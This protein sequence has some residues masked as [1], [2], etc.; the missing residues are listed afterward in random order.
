M[1]ELDV[2]RF[3][4][5]CRNSF[6]GRMIRRSNP[7]L[8]LGIRFTSCSVILIR[9]VGCSR[10][11]WLRADPRKN[12]SVNSRASIL[13][14][15]FE[16]QGKAAF[17]EPNATVYNVVIWLENH[18]FGDRRLWGGEA[19]EVA[20]GR[21]GPVPSTIVL[22]M[23]RLFMTNDTRIPWR[24]ILGWL[25]VA[26]GVLIIV[27]DFVES[28]HTFRAFRNA[29]KDGAI[30]FVLG[31]IPLVEAGFT[32]RTERIRQLEREN[33]ALR[34]GKSEQGSNPGKPLA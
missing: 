24:K 32:E 28:E 8:R 33:A 1:I 9:R 16:Q 7:V 20:G 5:S 17:D 10:Q 4:A 15:P 21:L 34:A 18:S 6:R 2:S 22:A 31:A 29:V 27:L 11:T 14:Q 19:R 23:R 26:A 25:L 3:R 13:P 30:F 12:F